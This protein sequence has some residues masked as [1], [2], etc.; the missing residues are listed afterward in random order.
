MDH[1][2]AYDEQSSHDLPPHANGYPHPSKEAALAGTQ[3]IIHINGRILCVVCPRWMMGTT[4]R[5]HSIGS[6]H[7]DVPFQAPVA[8]ST[9]NTEYL[10]KPPM[11]F[12]ASYD[13]LLLCVR[14]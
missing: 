8:V 14:A 4:K 13:F 5:P 7:D 12:Q 2:G 6:W 9:W 11:I 10:L 3:P 1:L